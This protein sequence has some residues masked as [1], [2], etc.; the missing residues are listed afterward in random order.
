MEFFFAELKK[1]IHK[2]IR[3]IRDTILKYAFSE[4]MFDEIFSLASVE[5][6]C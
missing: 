5:R 2:V 4:L 3:L 6:N 1:N